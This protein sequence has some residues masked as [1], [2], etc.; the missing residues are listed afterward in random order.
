MSLNLI[1]LLLIGSLDALVYVGWRDADFF[2]R[3]Q[4]YII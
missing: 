2:L 1:S 3:V 4:R